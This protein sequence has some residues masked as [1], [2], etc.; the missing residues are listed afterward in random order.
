MVKLRPFILFAGV[1]FLFLSCIKHK[2]ADLIVHNGTIYTCDMAFSSAQ[3]MA[4]KDG[5]IVEIGPEH[6]IL[7]KYNSKKKLDLKKRTVVPAFFDAHSY[8]LAKTLKSNAI[9]YD[10]LTKE[11][12][13]NSKINYIYN[14]PTGELQNLDYPEFQFVLR[15]FSGNTI[16]LDQRTFNSVF[17][18]SRNENTLIFDKDSI[19]KVIDYIE[20]NQLENF[21]S[22]DLTNELFK[23]G[24]SGCI[25]FGVNS[26][27]AEKI[28]EENNSTFYHQLILGGNPENFQWLTK[29]GRIDSGSIHLKGLSYFIDGGFGAKEALL[30]NPY[31]SEETNGNL[32][33]DSFAL[34]E[35]PEL[36]TSL[37]FQMIFHAYG[38]SAFAIAST[39]MGI[40]LKS[41]NDNRWRLEHNQLVDLSDV[42]KLKTFSILPS[43]QPTQANTDKG[44][45][46]PT[47]GKNRDCS[48]YNF[49]EL[50]NQNQFLASGSLFPIGEMNPFEQFKAL[51]KTEDCFYPI[52]R[53]QALKALTIWPAM[54]AFFENKTGS[55]E[56][57]KN[58][59]FVV[60]NIDL[61]KAPSEKISD[62]KIQRTYIKGQ[63]EFSIN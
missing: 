3:A 27:T 47:I 6:Q 37:N 52:E 44:K 25:S 22:K 31:D 62:T 24:Y 11:Q 1:T 14:V 23:N 60:L 4:I 57:G 51:T 18:G 61:M 45:V 9:E 33:A 16:K 43:V 20:K 35:L 40:A 34:Y 5:R 46:I 54:L 49:A 63:L 2:D 50:Y 15:S 29:T 55:L 30:K 10:N 26:N 53:K 12:L 8:L 48:S 56:V 39:Q 32:F 36:C 59:D 42:Q 19:T 58:A 13:G 28:I 7:N 17:K 38:D 41:V 21:I